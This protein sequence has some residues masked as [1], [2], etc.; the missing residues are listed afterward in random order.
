MRSLHLSA[1]LLAMFPT[2][3]RAA[4]PVHT[5]VFVAGQG[6]YHTCRIP[7]VIVAPKGTVLAFCEG[8]KTGRG[9]TGDI[10]LLLKRS[11]D[12]GQTWGPARV[13]WDDADNV[14]GN[15]CPVVDP[16]TG[17]I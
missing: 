15:P 13:V 6:G 2:P 12:G 7:S 1:L 4:E 9:D 11:T 8:R 14:C 16:K 3:V 10:D 5:R 17:T